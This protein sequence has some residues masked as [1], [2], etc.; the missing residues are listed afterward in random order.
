M[1]YSSNVVNVTSMVKLQSKKHL[2]TKH[3]SDHVEAIYKVRK[4][5]QTLWGG[6]LHWSV[7]CSLLFSPAGFSSKTK[8]FFFF[9]ICQFFNTQTYS[10]MLSWASTNYNYK[11]ISTGRIKEITV[12]EEIL[13]YAKILFLCT[14]YLC[15]IWNALVCVPMKL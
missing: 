3:E 13:L 12:V 5:N 2:T 11:I 9:G 7:P 10:I 6:P 14:S 15:I 8:V 1:L 4:D